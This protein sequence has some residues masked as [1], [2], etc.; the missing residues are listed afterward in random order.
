MPPAENRRLAY[1]TGS[2]PI[3]D[4]P[5]IRTAYQE[6]T[7]AQ[8]PRPLVAGNWKMNGLGASAAELGKII[9]GAR[10]LARVN[11]MVSPPSTWL[12]RFCA[13]AQG[14]PVA[15]G[16]QDCH[17]DPAGAFTGDVSAE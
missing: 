4:C 17:A 8:T 5:A 14:S 3:S 11:L 16:A 7:M 1:R 9:E 10:P 15:I 6:Q 2:R 12:A 13:L